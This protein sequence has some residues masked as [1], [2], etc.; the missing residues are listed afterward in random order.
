MRR[1][2]LSALVF[3][4]GI[5]AVACGDPVEVTPDEYASMPGFQTR[6]FHLEAPCMVEVQGYGMVDVEEEYLPNVVACENGGAP[7][8]ALKAQAVQARGFLYYKLFVAGETVLENSQSDQVYRCDHQPNGAGPEH[9]EAVQATKGQYLAWN[10]AI[11]ASFYVAGKRPPNPD[12]NDPVNSCNGVGGDR[13]LNTERFVTYNW[14]RSA[15]NIDMSTIG[16][17]PDDCT[18]NPHNRGCASQNGQSCLDGLGWKY[19]DMVKY[20]YGD[21]I[22]LLAADGQCGGPAPQQIDDFDR[23][24]GLKADGDYCFDTM[25]KVTC[26]AE[27]GSANETCP[28]GCVDGACQTVDPPDTACDGLADGWHCADTASRIECVSGE[29][30][31][32]ETCPNGCADAQCQESSTNNGNGGDFNNDVDVDDDMMNSDDPTP[33]ASAEFPAL[34]SISKGTSGGCSTLEKRPNPAALLIAFGLLALRRRRP[35]S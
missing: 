5:S 20:Y 12:V 19:Q 1:I 3:V 18:R 30:S 27:Y 28:T 33:N 11:I 7:P 17:V 15:C 6:V 8:E 25:T 13:D 24:C 22:Q 26:A 29:L 31:A 23:F 2:L 32:T 9:Y 4:L 10:D 21:D 35:V 34:V 14:G 16:W